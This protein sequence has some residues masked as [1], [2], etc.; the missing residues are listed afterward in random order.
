M[1][2]TLTVV[3]STLICSLC[4]AEPRVSPTLSLESGDFEQHEVSNADA[5]ASAH[6][7]AT[8]AG[9]AILKNGGNAFDAAITVS[10][11]LAVV[12]PYSSGIGGGGFW[13]LHQAS[14]QVQVMI[15]G[16]EKAPGQ[17][18]ADMY[19][20]A[21]GEVIPRA[22][23]DGALSAGIP[24]TIAA[25]VHL[26]E[27]YAKLSLAET[28]DPAIR[29]AKTG[30]P[31]TPRYRKMLGFRLDAL[32]ASPAAAAI[33]LR[34]NEIPELGE[35]IVQTDLATTL[36]NVA[37]KGNAG[38]YA[39]EI[40][41]KLVDGTRAAGGIWQLADLADYN[42]VEREPI[43]GTYKNYKITSAALPSS[44]GAVMMQT[45]NILERKPLDKLDPITRKHLIIEAMKRAYR[46]RAVYMGD[47]DFVPFPASI[48]SKPY[49]TMKAASIKLDRA[50]PAE[51]SET[52]R[53][54]GTDTTHFSVIDRVGNR[55]SATLSINYPFG[56]AFVVPG[57]GV[58]LNDEMDDFSIAPNTPNGYGLVGDR[59][60]AIAA[61]K[62]P[63][64]SMTPTFI[65]SDDQIAILGTPGGSRIISMVILGAL[66]FMQGHDVESWVSLPRYHHQF[67]PDLVQFEKDGLSEEEQSGLMKRGHVLKEMGRNYGNMQAILI[68]KKTGKTTAA[69]DPRGEGRAQ[70]SK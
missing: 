20:D 70:V 66:D 33:F 14:D 21:Q 38:F 55:V 22:S 60:N 36:E 46:D 53:S 34:D 11:V 7:L 35:L 17:A 58:L 24:G 50:T 48:L 6:P 45:L 15:D 49:A 26:S 67:M 39:G 18:H 69:S 27:K 28:L 19:L 29:I 44:G 8:E 25:L 61:G 64:S 37:A 12:E 31:V 2:Q 52:P 1:K 54:E 13:L 62:R 30:F 32:R 9:M 3:A 68:D 10:A 5:I 51:T 16:R 42:I 23:L 4:F 41:K 57:T 63:L 65:E 43:R 56:S 59:A 40:A 47:T